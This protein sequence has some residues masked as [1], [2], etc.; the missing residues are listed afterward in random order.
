M[1][2]W[3]KM[4]Q[5]YKSNKNMFKSISCY[6]GIPIF[7][8]KA[9]ATVKRQRHSITRNCLEHKQIQHR[10]NSLHSYCNFI[11]IK[12]MRLIIGLLKWEQSGYFEQAIY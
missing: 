10:K 9:R 11:N 12:S 5:V 6:H 1:E 4:G 2:Y 7:F 8:K 3:T